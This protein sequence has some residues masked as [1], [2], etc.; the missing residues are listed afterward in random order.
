LVRKSAA[1]RHCHAPAIVRLYAVCVLAFSLSLP[2]PACAQT[3]DLTAWFYNATA[4]NVEPTA[5]NLDKPDFF[6]G[7]TFS[8][9][10]CGQTGVSL[11][12]GI[13]Q[14][15]KYDRSAGVALANA[16]TDQCSVALFKASPPGVKV[17]DGDLSGYHTG[18]GVAIGS[19]YQKVL[20]AYGK[21]PV[22]PS[23]HFVL[24]YVAN[25]PSASVA[26]PHKSVSLPE[27]IVFV[28]DDNRVSSIAVSIDESGLF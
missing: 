23:S 16:S 13:W 24:A 9:M 6:G 20:S 5:V 4:L 3:K 1:K 8:A 2:T 10:H 22:R 19:S 11:A 15:V 27:T 26:L 12:N 18:R 14:L 25:V 28:I 7:S 17:P 21:S